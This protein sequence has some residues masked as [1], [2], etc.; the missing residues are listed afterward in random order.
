MIHNTD[1]VKSALSVVGFYDE[2]RYSCFLS[3]QNGTLYIAVN[4]NECLRNAHGTAKLL[5]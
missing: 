2:R 1:S 5:K 3:E 4:S